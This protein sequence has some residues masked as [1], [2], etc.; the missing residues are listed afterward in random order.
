MAYSTVSTKATGD[1]VAA[2]DWN[3]YIRD[4]LADHEARIGAIAYSGCRVTRVTD[5]A[6]ADNTL[7]AVTWTAET[8]DQGGW[9]PSSGTTVTV[10]TSALPSGY[11][12]LMVSMSVQIYWESNATGSRHVV[13]YK[14]G[15]EFAA[16]KIAPGF[17]GTFAQVFT[18]PDID[19]VPGD[20]FLVQVIH[21][22]GASLNIAG[23]TKTAAMSIRRVHYY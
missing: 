9:F 21:S 20:T 19:A 4:N 22:A 6:I 12:T 7:T 16:Q 3:T 18:A 14:N 10:P 8:T 13:L 23:A 1:T 5:Q 17:T 15:T 2:S 11:T